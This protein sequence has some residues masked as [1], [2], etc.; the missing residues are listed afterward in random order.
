MSDIHNFGPPVVEAVDVHHHYGE[1]L[2]RASFKPEGIGLL[3]GLFYHQ[4][5]KESKGRKVGEAVMR[6]DA[7]ESNAPPSLA[8]ASS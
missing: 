8:R 6:K 2:Q 7:E 3:A 4:I 1:G 5:A